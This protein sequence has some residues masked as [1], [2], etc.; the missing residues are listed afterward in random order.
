MSLWFTPKIL[1]PWTHVTS[2]SPRLKDLIPFTD[3]CQ[4]PL[5]LGCPKQVTK[6]LCTLG[7]LVIDLAGLLM[8]SFHINSH[9]V[10]LPI[11]WHFSI[12]SVFLLI[13][14]DFKPILPWV[15]LINSLISSNPNWAPSKSGHLITCT[16]PPD[17]ASWADKGS[18]WTANDWQGSPKNNHE[19]KYVT[20]HRIDS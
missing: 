1:W 3:T 17:A 6:L 18:Q 12:F 10:L 5:H 20:I 15:P 8:S 14:F 16:L 2:Q 7:S 13:N 4:K 11:P 9:Y 19:L